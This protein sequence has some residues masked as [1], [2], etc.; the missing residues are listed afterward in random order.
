[1]TQQLNIYSELSLFIVS[2]ANITI[3]IRQTYC[4]QRQQDL[5]WRESAEGVPVIGTVSP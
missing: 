2:G 4:V 1:M 5:P 3:E